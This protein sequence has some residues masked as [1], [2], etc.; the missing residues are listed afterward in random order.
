MAD[1]LERFDGKVVL[2][3]RVLPSYR[4]PFFDRL[5]SVCAGGLEVYAGMPRPGESILTGREPE[6]AR[7]VKA[8]NRHWFA[9][10]LYMLRQPGLITWLDDSTPEALVL[11]ANL[12][13]LDNWRAIHWA[14]AESVPVIGW[15]L[16]APAVSDGWN[17]AAWLWSRFLT[18]FDALITYS[19]KGASEYHQAGLEANRI[20]VA[21]NA[22]VGEPTEVPDRQPPVGRP[23][24]VLFVGRLQ[25][26]KNVDHL[27]RACA[28]L[29]PEVV[30]LR[31]VGEGP[32]EPTL[33]K[34]AGE[35]F[36]AAEFKGAQ[37]GEALRSSFEWADIFVLPGTGGLAVQQAM[38][39]G[40]PVVVARGDGTQED[41]VRPENGWLL[42]KE[43]PQELAAVLKEA[44]DIPNLLMEMGRAGADIV[45][46]E[47][48]LDA[49]VEVFLEALRGATERR[50]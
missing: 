42:E 32:E 12:R 5:A 28:R 38:A 25:A 8:D 45:R 15:G 10:G 11:E 41:L 6:R 49:M 33:G 34:M 7:W 50:G 14:K 23:L 9:G 39:H 16:G 1:N 30:S 2:Q 48:N 21:L 44:A 35:I 26:R 40:L 3:Q 47:V 13:Y 18:S 27:L 37:Q 20:H 46:E 4:I 22:A 29:G 19:S 36:P 31:I 43:S 24:R 17:P